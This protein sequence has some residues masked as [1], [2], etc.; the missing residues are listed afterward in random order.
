MTQSFNQWHSTVSLLL[1]RKKRLLKCINQML[2]GVLLYGFQRWKKGLY[3]SWKIYIKTIQQEMEDIVKE[4]NVLLQKF[5][6]EKDQDRIELNK[7]KKEKENIVKEKENIVKEK[8]KFQEEK[9]NFER[10][11][12]MQEK[13]ELNAQKLI[14][15][16]ESNK[17][18]EKELVNVEEKQALQ[19]QYEYDILMYQDA[20]KAL[21]LQ[22]HHQDLEFQSK[23]ERLK[24]KYE[25]EE[26]E[27]RLIENGATKGN[28]NMDTDQK[29][30]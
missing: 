26:G 7:Y 25:G 5:Q 29:S 12:N 17:I 22:L 14:V 11:Q 1:T 9:L 18:Q 10:K 4:K 30:K 19:L 24:C 21:Q 23:M 15:H 13:K 27:H 28:N 6:K 16:S 8:K 20:N 2:N 3:I